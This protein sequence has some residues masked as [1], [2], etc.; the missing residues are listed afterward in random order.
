MELY[1]ELT[2]QEKAYHDSMVSIAE[3]FGPFDEASSSIWVGYESPEE[4]D[5]AAIGVKCGNCSLHYEKE[6]NQLGCEIV[7]FNVQENGKCRLA[8]IPD[9]YVNVSKFWRGSFL[10]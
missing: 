10:K 5:E 3:E 6:N 7:S 8:A 9:G 1:D 2:P 4:N